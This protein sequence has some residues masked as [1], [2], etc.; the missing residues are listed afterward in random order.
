MRTAHILIVH[1]NPNQLERLIK[2]LKHPDFD[3]Y[4][5]V[6]K[7]VDISDF[8]YLKELENVFFIKNRV[9][10]N[11]GGY[12][13][14]EAMLGSLDEA[15]KNNYGFYNLLSAQ[16]YSLKKSDTIQELL[17]ENQD[18]SFIYYEPEEESEWWTDAV[19]RY[20]KYHLTDFSFPGK[21]FVE[22]L[23]NKV[24]PK[25]KFPLALK[26]Y[27]GSKACWWTINHES[28]VYLLDVFKKEKKLHSF[29]RFCWG[30]DEFVIP[31][32]LMNSPFRNK[33]VNNNWRYIHFPKGKA[34]PKIL[35]VA[36][37]EDMINSNMVFARK[38]DEEVDAAILTKLDQYIDRLD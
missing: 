29:L 26:L 8:L 20:Q 2:R 13:T 36:D 5:H 11:W 18:K 4:I 34:N 33:I 16:D 31:S 35:R 12:S 19:K 23:I 21:F 6:D 10:C 38:F 7:K 1:K 3:F 37:F 17:L 15:L 28:A 14:L 25:R 32:I 9:V 22:R 24:L 27:G 30:T